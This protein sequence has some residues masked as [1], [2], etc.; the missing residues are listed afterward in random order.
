[1]TSQASA[2][3]GHVGT[4]KAIGLDGKTAEFKAKTKGVMLPKVSAP[5]ENQEIPEKAEDEPVD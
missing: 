3:L 1:M 2:K 4:F 5:V